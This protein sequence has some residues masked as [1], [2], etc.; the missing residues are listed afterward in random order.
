[1]REKIPD[2]FVNQDTKELTSTDADKARVLSEFFSSLFTTENLS[3]IPAPVERRFLAELTSA[4]IEEEDVRQLLQK[5]KSNKSTGPD[6]VH[7]RVLR[8]MATTL[9]K[10]LTT[11]FRKSLAQG[12]IP[13]VWK[14]ATTTAIRKEENRQTPDNYR[15]VSLTCI[16]CKVM[17]SLIRK[18]IMKH[19]RQPSLLRPTMRRE[20]RSTS[21]QLLATVE[22]W[23]RAR[24]EGHYV[25]AYFLDLQKAFDSIGATPKTPGQAEELWHSRRTTLL[26]KSIP[27]QLVTECP[28]KQNRV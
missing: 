11:I 25:D 28:S 13:E 19:E 3:N 22:D 9:C 20:H 23:M 27:P 24:E 4:E 1:M 16:L 17:E 5:L 8:E 26:D 15:P 12:E 10:P 18:A 21:I 14:K 2:P 6:G 7:P